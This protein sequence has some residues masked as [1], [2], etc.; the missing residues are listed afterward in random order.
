M[1]LSLVF[2]LNFKFEQLF[3]LVE[4]RD[5]AS[6][7]LSFASR[8]VPKYLLSHYSI[9]G[10][11]VSFNLALTALWALSFATRTLEKYI[12]LHEQPVLPNAVLACK[13]QTCLFRMMNNLEKV[14]ANQPLGVFDDGLE[15]RVTLLL[16]HS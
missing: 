2:E 13:L 4:H 10:L 3:N 8:L 5:F 11:L 6:N 12:S 15:A 7:V 14:D 16:L 9:W 1:T